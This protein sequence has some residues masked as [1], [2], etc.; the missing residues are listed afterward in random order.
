M[1]FVRRA[2]RML[3]FVRCLGTERLCPLS[4]HYRAGYIKQLNF[5]YFSYVLTFFA[6]FYTDHI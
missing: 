5:R 1:L 3:T 2:A 4:V 6:Q